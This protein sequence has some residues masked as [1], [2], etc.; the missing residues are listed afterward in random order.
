MNHKRFG[1]AME[2]QNKNNVPEYVKKN[3]IEKKLP[4]SNILWLRANKTI[5][6]QWKKKSYF[7]WVWMYINIIEMFLT[8]VAKNILYNCCKL[9]ILEDELRKLY[10][11]HAYIILN[12]VNIFCWLV[13]LLVITKTLW[14]Y[15]EIIRLIYRVFSIIHYS[16]CDCIIIEISI[17]LTKHTNYVST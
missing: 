13:R 7:V 4:K 12:R 9:V 6:H 5:K 1:N 16:S 15:I 3:T 14:S 10:D 17:V 2:K 8:H 11:T